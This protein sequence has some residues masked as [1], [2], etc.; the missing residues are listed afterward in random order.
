[1]TA[2]SSTSKTRS[3]KSFVWDVMRPHR[4]WIFLS[5]FLGWLSAA[6]QVVQQKFVK[7]FIDDG[8]VTKDINKIIPLAILLTVIIFTCGLIDFFHRF[9][10][11]LSVERSVRDLRHKVFQRMLIMSEKG[12]YKINSGKALT[13]I[14]SD[15]Y[16]FGIGMVQAT[17]ITREPMVIVFMVIW[18]FTLNVK[19]TLFCFFAIGVLPLVGGKLAKSARRNHFRYQESIERISSHTMEAVRGRRTALTFGRQAELLR[20][21]IAKSEEAFGFQVR[22]A[23]TEE[24]VNPVTKWVTSLVGAVLLVFASILIFRGELTMGGLISFMLGAGQLQGPLKLLN[25]ANIRI[26]QFIATGTRLNNL[27]SEPLDEIGQAQED[28]LFVAKTPDAGVIEEFRELTFKNLSFRYPNRESEEASESNLLSPALKN[29]DFTLT[30]GQKIALV[31]KSG[32]GKTTLSLLA[33]RLMDPESGEILLNGK[34]LKNWDLAELRKYFSYVSQDVFLFQ[35]SLRENFLLS[36]PQATDAQIFKALEQA[37]ILKFVQSLPK[38]LDTQ[39]GEMGSTLSGGEKQRLAIAR[40][41]LRDSPILVLDEATSQLDSFS[42]AIVQ[43]SLKSLMKNRSVLLIA[44]RLS[45]V[46]EADQ[47]L[48]F[49]QG[50]IIERGRPQELLNNAAGAFSLL[51]RTQFQ[52]HPGIR[53]DVS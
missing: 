12:S 15:V 34:E 14:V 2:K 39:I 45:T 52:D 53:N 24:A 42:E 3:V 9:L 4:L 41:F 44:H 27:L 36:K 8:L 43:E 19:L 23:R 49:E 22:L 31:G 7:T 1:M 17:D 51:W 47:V 46:K 11:R 37:A 10:M 35:R 50:Q 20:E 25:Q 26:Q 48:V 38:G 18:M 6:I 13:H 33:M 30:R 16:S 28:L 5:V 32:S 40:A 29:I 21:F